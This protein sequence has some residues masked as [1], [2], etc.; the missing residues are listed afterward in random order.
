MA[1][2]KALESAG[3]I[4]NAEKA[5]K[6]IFGNGYGANEIKLYKLVQTMSPDFLVGEGVVRGGGTKQ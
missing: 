1:A 6:K 3:L 4:L 2:V 5:L